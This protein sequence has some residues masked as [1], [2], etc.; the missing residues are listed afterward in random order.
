MENNNNNGNEYAEGKVAKAIESKT[1][2]LPSDIFLWSGLGALALSGALFCMGKKHTSLMVGQWAAPVLIMG[3][4]DKIVKE[5][6][7]DASDDGEEY[8]DDEE[9]DQ[10]LM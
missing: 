3:L 6:G 9:D 8:F 5:L 2:K 1:A 10:D 4:Y 7:H